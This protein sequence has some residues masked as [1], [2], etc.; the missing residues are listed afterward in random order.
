[1]FKVGRDQAEQ[2]EPV[3]LA[4]LYN[5][6][7]DL[8]NITIIN[9]TQGCGL[10]VTEVVENYKVSSSNL[11]EDKKKPSDSSHMS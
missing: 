11:S 8:L 1:M 7:R 6:L 10:V 3:A 2:A 9:C 5:I 4:H